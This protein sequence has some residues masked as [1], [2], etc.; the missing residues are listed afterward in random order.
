MVNLGRGVGGLVEWEGLH[1]SCLEAS[2]LPKGLN[3]GP[4]SQS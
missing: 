3:L 2:G 1:N 4:C